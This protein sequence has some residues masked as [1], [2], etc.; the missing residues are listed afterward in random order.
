ML[1]LNFIK[2]TRQD[3]V[4]CYSSDVDAVKIYMTHTAKGLIAESIPLDYDKVDMFADVD[5]SNQVVAIEFLDASEVFAC[6]FFNDVLPLGYK[7]YHTFSL[8]HV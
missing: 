2:T 1:I 4:F 8:L 3:T 5:K 6:H 7:K